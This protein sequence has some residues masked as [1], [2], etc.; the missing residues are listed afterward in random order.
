[1]RA[2]AEAAGGLEESVREELCRLREENRQLRRENHE[3]GM[4]PWTA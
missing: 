1:M 3:I 4:E 2:D